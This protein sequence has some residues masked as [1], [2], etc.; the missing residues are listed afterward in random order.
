MRKIDINKIKLTK[1]EQAVDDALARG[2]YHPVSKEEQDRIVAAIKAYQ[3]NAVQNIRINR[4]DLQR[5]KD[6]AKKF[7][8]RYQTFIGQILHRV[9]QD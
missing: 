3:K 1:E 8:V 5:L 7:G 9:A 4:F 6:K 2:E